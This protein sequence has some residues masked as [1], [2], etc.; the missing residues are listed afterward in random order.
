M[1]KLIALTFIVIVL[2]ANAFGEVYEFTQ[3]NRLSLIEDPFDSVEQKIALIKNAKHHIHILTFFWDDTGVAKRLSEELNKANA[4]GVEV[5]ILTSFIP[6]LGVD[7]LGKGK[8]SLNLDSKKAT[9]SY[10]ALSPGKDFSI[11]HNLHEKIFIADGEKAIIGGRNAS[12]SS[13]AGKDVE[14]LM[15]GPVVN[16]VQHHFKKM[17]DF[18]AKK[19][20]KRAI[21]SATDL[22]FFPVQPAFEN[23]EEARILSHE[24]ILHQKNDKMGRRERT[25]QQDDILDTVTNIAFKKLRT[26]N[27][28][29][30]PTKRYSEFLNKKLS[31]GASIEMITNSIETAK[32]SSNA[33]YIYSLPEVR[34]F[35]NDG[36]EL[37]Q[38]EK[39]QKFTYVHEKV[40]IFDEDRVIIG[41]HN[42]GVGSTSV[43]NEIAID[44]KSKAIANRL[45]EVFD[46]EKSNQSVTKKADVELLE[47]QIKKNKNKIKAFK[48]P[49]VEGILREI[50]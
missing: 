39:G 40:M 6:T 50:Y 5:R 20:S 23:G 43:S 28:F 19:K 11:T 24:A 34:D 37:Y 30:V 41:S 35:V 2:S 47:K 26:Y 21:F 36:L 46:E 9:F 4:R 33:G 12:D 31:E 27:Y 1:K 14:V 45:I 17:F 3:G 32:F 18:L 8:R 22:N 13:L 44:I 29:I 10:L 15:E 49:F 48:I 16:Q 38:W 42:F 25:F 7:I